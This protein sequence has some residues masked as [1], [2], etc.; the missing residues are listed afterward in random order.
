MEQSNQPAQE[1]QATIDIRTNGMFQAVQMQRDAATAQ[2][3]NL[4]GELA[5]LQARN[6]MASAAAQQA[7][8]AVADRD[9]QIAEKDAIIASLNE[10]IK[11]LRAKSNESDPAEPQPQE[12]GQQVPVIRDEQPSQQEPVS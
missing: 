6:R 10:E 8:D 3:I 11:N 4:N 7:M 12:Q 1:D 5:V 2:V 9:N